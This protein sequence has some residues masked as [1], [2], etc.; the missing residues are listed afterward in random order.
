MIVDEELVP[1]FRSRERTGSRKARDRIVALLIRSLFPLRSQWAKPK[2]GG[3]L[4]L[5]SSL[6]SP[7]HLCSQPS[8]LRFSPLFPSTSS[9]PSLSTEH[10]R[11]PFSRLATQPL[12]RNLVLLRFWNLSSSSSKRLLC[13]FHQQQPIILPTSRSPNDD[14]AYNDQ[15]PPQR[16]DSFSYA[17]N[18][19]A[20]PLSSIPPSSAA[21]RGPNSADGSYTSPNRLTTSASAGGLNQRRPSA[22]LSDVGSYMSNGN[23]GRRAASIRSA[24]TMGGARSFIS[25]RSTGTTNRKAFVSTRLKGEIYKPWLENPDPAQK[26]ARWIIIGSVILGFG[27]VG[28]RESLL[29]STFLQATEPLGRKPDLFF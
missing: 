20:I 9:L 16:D 1:V 6:P 26:W 17:P 28:L 22:G 21:Y 7:F 13:P 23:A 2:T 10:G 24:G 18:S 11:Q 29:P 19:N 3:G 12:R 5:A 27:I 4:A 25:M 14:A 15:H 8:S